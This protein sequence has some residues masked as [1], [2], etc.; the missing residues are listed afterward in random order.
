MPEGWMD[1]NGVLHPADGL[2]LAAKR[3][4]PHMKEAFAMLVLS[5]AGKLLDMKL[6][7]VEF[8]V[9]MALVERLRDGA[10]CYA[11][12]V[13]LAERIG[14]HQVQVSRA[15]A[16]LAELGVIRRMKD[17]DGHRVTEFDPSIMEMLG[18]GPAVAERKRRRDARASAARSAVVLEQSE[19]V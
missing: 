6:T 8:F 3:R 17:D 19:S 1:S 4:P 18:N 10:R 13:R 9:V 12:Q 15:M 16:R 2:R 5:G 14:V 7:R 11:T